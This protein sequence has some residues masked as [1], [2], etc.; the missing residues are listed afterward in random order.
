MNISDSYL[1]VRD[2]RRL[3]DLKQT[4]ALELGFLIFGAPLIPLI[5]TILAIKY[6]F[7]KW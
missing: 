7:F 1:F 4:T 2:R 6:I 3:N 5:S